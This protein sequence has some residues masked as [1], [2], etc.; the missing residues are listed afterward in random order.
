MQDGDA[1]S[2][3]LPAT[4]G[5]T[6]QQLQSPME[7]LAAQ[8][9]IRMERAKER[10]PRDEADAEAGVAFRLLLDPRLALP[11]QFDGNLVRAIKL[12]T[13]RNYYIAAVWYGAPTVT[14]SRTAP[15]I[16][17]CHGN[18][19]DVGAM[20]PLQVLLAHALE[21]HVLSLDYAGYGESGGIP[22]EHNTYGDLQAAYDYAMEHIVNNDP[23]RI[24]LY[25][26]SVGGGPVCELAA[27]L[28]RKNKTQVGGIVLHS[29]F[30]SGMRVLTPSRLLSCLD[31]YPNIDRIQHVSCP[32]WVIHG[33]LDQEVPIEHG[34][35]LY[36]NCDN[37][38]EP[39]WVPDRG[40]NDITEGA[41]K[42][43]EYMRRFRRFLETCQAK[44]QM[45]EV[46]DD[47]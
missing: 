27:R 32:V 5:Q 25:G 18:A 42:L 43:A 11:T 8:T 22:D 3:D 41:G 15:C 1:D 13:A 47:D 36:D 31:I 45:P 9:Q 14:Q 33:R 29:A 12:A 23:S 35:D 44:E 20:F 46:M 38:F 26:Q 40:H 24:I 19:T 28:A 2:N 10:A 39:W 16:I 37:P 7:Q 4:K 6:A 34:R 17:Y 21:C 30:T